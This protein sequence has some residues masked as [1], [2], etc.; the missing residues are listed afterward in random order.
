M[1]GK[2]KSILSALSLLYVLSFAGIAV[3]SS[4]AELATDESTT[5]VSV[6]HAGKLLASANQPPLTK[7]SIVIEDGKIRQVIPGYVTQESLE[8]DEVIEVIDLKDK[9]VL[10]GL[11]DSHVHLQMGN[12]NTK[13]PDQLSE[14]EFA[15]HGAHSANLTLSA[16][17]TTVR[18]LGSP[19]GSIFTLRDSIAAGL[20]PGPR[21]IAAG[22]LISI[23]GGHGGSFCDSAAE[24]KKAVRQQIHRGA[25]VIKIAATAG[26]DGSFDDQ[27][28]MDVAE[29]EAAINAAHKLRRKVAAHAHTILGI[30]QAIN[31]GVDS[32]EHGTFVDKAVAR[33]MKKNN[34]FLVPTLTVRDNLIR[35]IDSMS[36]DLQ[37]RVNLILDS[38]SQVMGDAHRIGVK[39]ALGSDAGVVKH[40]EN[41]RELEWLV[42]VGLSPAEAIEA[43]TINAAEL[44]GL[45]EQIGTIEAGKEADIIAV[46]G[47]P[48]KNIGALKAVDF[49]MKSGETF[50]HH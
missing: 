30:K 42:E 36:V 40:G 32:I 31:A 38:T 34:V 9:F 20:I 50:I 18:D 3:S 19:N 49:V 12:T 29:M 28:E 46:S 48:L 2:S 13:E 6:L 7:M 26:G 8:D 45:G 23:T 37:E 15:L 24:C 27:P 5:S 33:T 21:V 10:A 25:D 39:F 35:D 44:L 11:I 17:F 14:A 43:A 41:A 47:G 16:G 1:K 22:T 4:S